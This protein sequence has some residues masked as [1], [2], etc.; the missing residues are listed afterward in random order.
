VASDRKLF[1]SFYSTARLGGVLLS[2]GGGPF[3]FDIQIAMQVD[4]VVQ[5]FDV[6]G[7]VETG[8]FLG[9]TT[10]YLART[11]PD[12]PVRSCDI[13]PK[14]AEFAAQRTA[15]CANA[16]VLAGSSPEVLPK[17]SDGLC[18]PLYLLDAHWASYWPIVDELSIIERGVIAIDDFRIG[19]PRFSYDTY[20]GLSCGP[21]LV[22]K[23]L[24]DLCEMYVGNPTA[25][26]PYPCLQVTRRKGVGF[27]SKTL[28]MS[29]LSANE[30][31][32]RIS[33]RPTVGYPCWEDGMSAYY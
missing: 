29:L 28:D 14:F 15:R 10:S 16:L 27:A 31:F 2:D 19:H 21:D 24:P 25:K 13:V 6:D 32:A 5:A 8:C 4:E 7:F 30:H 17:L 18:R 3:G 22:S 20:D 9:D 12:L 23:T 26:Y 11:Y 33:L 1:E